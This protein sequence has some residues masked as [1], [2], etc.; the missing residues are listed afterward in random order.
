MS[1]QLEVGTRPP[2]RNAG[3]DSYVTEIEVE[4]DSDVPGIATELRLE[5]AG[6]NSVR[7]SIPRGLLHWAAPIG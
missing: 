2:W 7:G 1:V 5:S 4:H 6:S 3:R